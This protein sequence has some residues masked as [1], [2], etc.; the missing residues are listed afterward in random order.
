M[1]LQ[2]INNIS[3]CPVIGNAHLHQFNKQETYLVTSSFDKWI[4]IWSVTDGKCVTQVKLP[5]NT[6]L[7]LPRPNEK[8]STWVALKWLS[9][10]VILSSGLSGE[11]LAWN[12]RVNHSNYLILKYC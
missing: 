4:K 7:H 10:D 9:E 12:M 3:W 8:R 2:D 11:L 6:G 5:T 1:N